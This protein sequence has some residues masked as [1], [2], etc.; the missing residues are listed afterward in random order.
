MANTKKQISRET[1]SLFEDIITSI[2]GELSRLINESKSSYKSC[3]SN[4][5]KAKMIKEAMQTYERLRAT[6][7]K[8]PK[9]RK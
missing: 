5:Q 2:R 1:D 7:I 4:M 8:V 3:R 6:S 9:N